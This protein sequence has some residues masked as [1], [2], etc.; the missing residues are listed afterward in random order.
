MNPALTV[1]QPDA[2]AALWDVFSA[3]GGVRLWL[4]DTTAG[5][6]FWYSTQVIRVQCSDATK[7]D[8]YARASLVEDIILGQEGAAWED[9]RVIA[10]RVEEGPRWAPTENG[11]P[12]YEAAYALT[13][14]PLDGGI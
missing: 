3:F 11:G 2:E 10:V 5:Y 4:E 13:V 7:E 9:G 6:P 12:R 8:A 1:D 14:R